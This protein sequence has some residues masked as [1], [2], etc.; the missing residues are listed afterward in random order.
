MR[1]EDIELVLIG[2]GFLDNSYKSVTDDIKSIIDE[3]NFKHGIYLVLGN[4]EY[5]GGY[6][7]IEDTHT[8][9]EVVV[10]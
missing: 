5:Y 3:I 10:R 6:R 8:E 4:H 2:G 7:K 9:L 1:N